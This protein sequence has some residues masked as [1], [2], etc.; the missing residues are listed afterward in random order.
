M[1]LGQGDKKQVES[2]R[3]GVNIVAAKKKRVARK[4]VRTWIERRGAGGGAGGERE[5]REGAEK[6]E[7][8]G[9][10]EAKM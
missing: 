7:E 4:K 1:S 2:K 6:G 3:E 5:G 8:R 10:G 9:G